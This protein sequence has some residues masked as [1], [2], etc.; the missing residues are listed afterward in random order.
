LAHNNFRASI[1]FA[2]NFAMKSATAI[3]QNHLQEKYFIDY[4][5]KWTTSLAPLWRGFF[6][7]VRCPPDVPVAVERRRSRRQPCAAW[8]GL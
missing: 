2:I 8:A 3:E 6:L 4:D 7:I 5:P 1:N